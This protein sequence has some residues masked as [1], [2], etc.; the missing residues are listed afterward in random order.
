[1]KHLSSIVLG[2]ALLV[3]GATA[4]FDDPTEPL[5]NGASRIELSR[6]T[7]FVT[8]GDSLDVKAEVKDD[9][10]NTYNATPATWESVDA[11]VAVVHV[12]STVIP[13][14]AF[15]RAF[16][17]TLSPGKTY[18]RL[19]IGGLRD[20]IA[21]WGVPTVFGGTITS[22]A[23]P[24]SRDTIT[25]NSTAALTF[26]T[27]ANASTVT[28]DDEETHVV[29]QTATQ[30]RFLAPPSDG[31]TV[32]ISNVVLNGVVTIPSLDAT[33]ALTVENPE[34]SALTLY[35]DYH[36]TFGP[37]SA[38]DDYL[39][40]T[41]T[42]GDSVRIEVDW[43]YAADIDGYLLDAASDYCDLD[44]CAMGTSAKPEVVE[45]R[46]VAGNTYTLNVYLYD[47]GEVAWT[48]Y[49]VRITKIE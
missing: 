6:S 41:P 18:V 47:I 27:G 4:C 39:E 28:V 38:G 32:T 42:T 43:D 19:T 46:L 16:I 45:V 34:T 49:T 12:D 8:V 15:S 24:T 23:N 3:M 33:T 21:V 35:T 1:M 20:S 31:A 48:N 5:R 44:G 7:I 10:G 13:G 2:A 9:Q 26:T 40:F 11:A 29:S 17:R 14:D 37:G 22:V 36:G 30:I 25:V